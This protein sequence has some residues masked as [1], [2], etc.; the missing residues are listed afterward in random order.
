MRT[1]LL[2][3]AGV[4]ACASAACAPGI[5]Q[6]AAR[7]ARHIRMLNFWLLRWSDGALRIR[8]H[9]AQCKLASAGVDLGRA[10]RP[11]L[12]VSAVGVVKQTGVAL[13]PVPRASIFV[14][15]HASEGE[16]ARQG[17]RTR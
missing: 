16:S 1:G 8:C 3:H 2:G 13:G 15:T 10:Y 14:A 5:S 6:R 9:G 4:C 7:N 12:A 17:F 11:D